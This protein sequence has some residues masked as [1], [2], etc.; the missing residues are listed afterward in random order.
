MGIISAF[1]SFICHNLYR[2]DISTSEA[3]M[4]AFLLLQVMM[5]VPPSNDTLAL[6]RLHL[7]IDAA[8]GGQNPGRIFYFMH[9]GKFR[10]MV[11]KAY[12]CAVAGHAIPLLLD[13]GFD[14][15]STT[16][17]DCLYERD[18]GNLLDTQAYGPDRRYTMNKRVVTGDSAGLAQIVRAARHAG[19]SPSRDTVFISIHFDYGWSEKANGAFIIVPKRDTPQIATALAQE[20]RREGMLQEFCPATRA[21]IVANDE[22]HLENLFILRHAPIK[23]FVLIEL[24]NMRNKRDRE[25]MLS[26]E[27]RKV[28]ANIIVRAVVAYANDRY[29][30]ALR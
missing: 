29:V 11:E 7:V 19:G 27:G 22:C 9:E 25:L 15:S 13:E 17:G 10:T 20:F 14:V 30:S 18:E 16:D 1:I 8:H 12:T 5:A 2:T 23:E 24:G 4:M 26:P 6:P 28:Y 3:E 21:S